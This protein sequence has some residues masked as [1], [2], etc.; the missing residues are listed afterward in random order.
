MEDSSNRSR[1]CLHSAEQT[2]SSEELMGLEYALSGSEVSATQPGTALLL[3]LR[4]G[5]ENIP[6]PPGEVN[7]ALE[8]VGVLLM[9]E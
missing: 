3:P 6:M 1:C 8:V 7:Q 4:T 2:L 9:A 5:Q